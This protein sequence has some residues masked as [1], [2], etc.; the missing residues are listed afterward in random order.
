MSFYQ[1]FE[2]V[3]CT[4]RFNSSS[5]HRRRRCYLDNMSKEVVTGGKSKTITSFA[6]TKTLSKSVA[7]TVMHVPHSTVTSRLCETCGKSITNQGW[8]NHIAKY[9]RNHDLVPGQG[10]HVNNHCSSITFG[11]VK[12][13]STDGMKHKEI[14]HNKVTDGTKC[15]ET[16]QNKV[17]NDVEVGVDEATEE[18]AGLCH[19]DTNLWFSNWTIKYKIDILDNF[20]CNWMKKPTLR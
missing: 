3:E 18:G 14:T 7:R 2:F 13:L 4:Q 1:I 9:Q 12:L 8:K 5:L 10:T 15:E 16:P 17:K 6:I 20:R 11:K 19:R